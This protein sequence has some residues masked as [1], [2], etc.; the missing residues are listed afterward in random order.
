MRV[1]CRFTFKAI[2]IPLGMDG[3]RARV[4]KRDAVAFSE[5]ELREGLTLSVGEGF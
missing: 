1:A 4:G 2:N 3:Y 5:S